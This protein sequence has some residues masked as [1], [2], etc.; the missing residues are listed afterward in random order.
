[1]T[2]PLTFEQVVGSMQR[3]ALH[4]LKP[5]RE[6]GQE[7]AEHAAATELLQ[8]CDPDENRIYTEL[9]SGR[10]RAQAPLGFYP[11]P[12]GPGGRGGFSLAFFRPAILNHDAA[13]ESDVEVILLSGTPPSRL[14]LRFERGRDEDDTHGYGHMQFTREF[15]PSGPTTDV[16]DWMPLSY[17]AFP[18][19]CIAM[20]DTWL[21]VLVSL[22]GLNSGR[23]SGLGAVVSAIE[24]DNRDW[25]DG[26]ALL[27]RAR[28]LFY[29]A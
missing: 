4:G 6:F 9:V 22:Y 2:E 29:S 28:H 24:G 5:C 17:P 18:T 23:E 11:M 8:Q 19:R 20:C 25:R 16:P 27:S 10:L 14:G 3:F 12:L 15:R 21:A 26:E 13:P 1:M 7:N